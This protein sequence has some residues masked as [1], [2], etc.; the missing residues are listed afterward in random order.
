MPRALYPGSF[1]PLTNGHV[2]VIDRAL[3]VFGQLLVAVAVNPK[4]KPLFSPRARVEMI[5]EVFSRQPGVEVDHFSGLLV[6]YARSRGAGVIVRGLRAVSDF[7][8]EFQMAN[9]NRKLAP[10]LE[11][12]FVMTGEGHFYVS[13]Q[14]VKEVAEL[15][16]RVNEFVPPSVA[17]RLAKR[18]GGKK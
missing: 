1:D 11:T 13:S 18:L 17:K 4:K 14:T 8:Y 9:M 16:G 5:R 12:F 10:E 15:G 3:R 6:D 7:E 2:D